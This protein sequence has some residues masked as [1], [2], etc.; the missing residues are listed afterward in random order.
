MAVLSAGLAGLAGNKHSTPFQF[1]RLKLVMVLAFVPSTRLPIP[2]A[3]NG[4]QYCLASKTKTPKKREEREGKSNKKMNVSQ[5]STWD[6]GP[7]F[8]AHIRKHTQ[9]SRA[10]H[11]EPLPRRRNIKKR[12]RPHAA[13]NRK[14]DGN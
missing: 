11:V 14:M 7:H 4:L 12:K 13:H 2:G 3:S 9:P 10:E 6:I 1:L 8:P 5:N